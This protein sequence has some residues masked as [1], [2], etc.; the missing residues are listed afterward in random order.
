MFDR[1]VAVWSVQYE[2]LRGRKW[3]PPVKAPTYLGAIPPSPLPHI[4]NAAPDAAYHRL[5]VKVEQL[6]REKGRILSSRSY[7]LT[8]PLRALV[9][10]ARTGRSWLR[11]RGLLR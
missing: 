8:A 3:K 7:R 2:Q 1:N 11:E 9:D 6:E 10:R 5:V 4:A